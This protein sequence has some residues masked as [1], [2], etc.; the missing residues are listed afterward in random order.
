MDWD[1]IG[2]LKQQSAGIHFLASDMTGGKSCWESDLKQPVAIIIGS[3]ATG[4]SRQAVDLSD[5]QI[6]I[7]MQ[8]SIESLNASTA[9]SILLFEVIR[10]RTQ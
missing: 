7:P 6:H 2:Q 3:E 5:G 1:E 4:V 9:A 8:G 10:Q